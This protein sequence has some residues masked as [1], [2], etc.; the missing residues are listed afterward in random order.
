[1]S[2]RPGN[3]ENSTLPNYGMTR[4]PFFRTS[5]DDSPN[6]LE[7][8]FPFPRE[9]RQ[10]RGYVPNLPLLPTASSAALH[11]YPTALITCRALTTAFPTAS[12]LK[13]TKTSFPFADQSLICPASFFMAAGVYLRR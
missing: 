7:N 11:D 3:S 4:M 1:M 12:L 10:P 13:Y 9:S 2:K 5:K 8:S 6:L